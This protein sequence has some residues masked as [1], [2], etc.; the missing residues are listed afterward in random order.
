MGFVL[1]PSE[2]AFCLE[3][4]TQTMAVGWMEKEG[5]QGGDEGGRICCHQSPFTSPVGS[6]CWTPCRTGESG[7]Q[8]RVTHVDTEGS[9][10]TQIKAR[11]FFFLTPTLSPCH[12]AAIFLSTLT[13]DEHQ[14]QSVFM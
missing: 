10:T 7:G 11:C 9:E 6:F 14:Y 5:G 13:F 3:A 1:K 4:D 2:Q 12:H 8:D